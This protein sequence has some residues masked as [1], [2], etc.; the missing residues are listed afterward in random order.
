MKAKD[1]KEYEYQNLQEIV[2]VC[3]NCG[4]QNRTGKYTRMIDP[5]N[6]YAYSHGYCEPCGQQVYS[7]LEAEL[8]EG[9]DST[10]LHSLLIKAK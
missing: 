1:Q 10:G 7:E 3:M 5:E 4:T 2:S 6:R 9:G 8:R